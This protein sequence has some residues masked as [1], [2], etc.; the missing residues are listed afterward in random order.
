MSH[1]LHLHAS[2]FAYAGAGC[3]LL[4]ESG[5]GK[6]SALAHAL[7][8]GAMLIADDQVVLQDISSQL[9]AQAPPEIAGV[10]ELRGLG[11]IRVPF[12]DAHPIH[13]AVELTHDP[14]DRL[15]TP[16]TREF[17]GVQL[18]L[19]HLPAALHTPV[20]SLLLYLQAMQE[21]RMVPEDWRPSRA[22]TGLQSNLSGGEGRPN[23]RWSNSDMSATA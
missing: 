9:I 10:L 16:H 15:P 14:I 5:S 6:S 12:V 22:A 18:P 21:R 20:A 1:P 2:A 17:L 11:L 19:L 4:G 7:L 8:H 3:L 23:Q 13:L